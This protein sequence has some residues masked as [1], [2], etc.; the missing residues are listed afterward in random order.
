M[1]DSDKPQ[2]PP[3]DQPPAEPQAQPEKYPK[4]A[5]LLRKEGREIKREKPVT[6]KP[7]GLDQTG[8]SSCQSTKKDLVTR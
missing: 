8:A 5:K 2:T 1:S 6:G 3:S 4:L 7:P